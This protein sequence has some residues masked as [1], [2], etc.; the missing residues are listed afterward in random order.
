MKCPKGTKI[1][2]VTAKLS[3]KEEKKEGWDNG[4]RAKGWE[5]R[6]TN[7]GNKNTEEETNFGTGMVAGK[8]R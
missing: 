5:P 8:D 1:E 2:T 4:R 6:H 7:D 3:E